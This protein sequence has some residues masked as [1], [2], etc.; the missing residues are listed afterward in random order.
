MSNWTKLA[1]VAAIVVAVVALAAWR[2]EAVSTLILT[3]R[4]PLPADPLAVSPAQ[5]SI[6]TGKRLVH[7]DGCTACHGRDLTGRVMFSGP[8]GTNF[9]APNLTRVVRHL[10]DAQLAAAIRFGV[11]PNGTTLIDMPV[12]KFLRSSDSDIAAIIA[13]LRSLPQAA[14]GAPMPHWALGGR[15]MLAMGL[16]QIDAGTANPSRRGPRQTP[17]APAALGRYIAQVQ[18]SG[19]HGR[20]LGGNPED[21]SPDLH[22]AI[23]SYSQAA[24]LRFFATGNA[25]KDHPTKRMTQVIQDQFKYLTAN[26][27]R[28]LYGHL[29]GPGAAAAPA[30]P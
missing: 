13:Y 18:C 6:K 20:D 21:D 3:A 11:R 12:G 4:H 22:K 2:I 1:I 15:M 16:M 7:L 8:F 25:H 30:T 28:A 5:A 24:F 23:K 26:E 17:T 29:A 27:V 19:C 10:S 14:D 9:V